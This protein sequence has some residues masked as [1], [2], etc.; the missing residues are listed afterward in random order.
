MKQCYRVVG[1]ALLLFLTFSYS[2]LGQKTYALGVGGGVAIPVGKLSDT[3]KTGYNGI[4]ALAIGVADLPIGVRFDGIYNNF[5]FRTGPVGSSSSSDLR[6]MG[7]LGNLVF[8]FSGTSAKPYVI[9][10][11]GLY[12]TKGDV[13]GEKSE[14]DFGF[15][16]GLGATFGVGPFATFLESRYHSISRNAAKGGVIQFVPITVGLMF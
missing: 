15:N 13:P 10:G 6:V 8:A 12:N 2:A 4:V 11:G 7:A 14:N 3:Q 16:A 1:I 9:V 5:S